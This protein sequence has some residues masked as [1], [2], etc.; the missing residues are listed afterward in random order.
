MSQSPAPA[1]RPGALPLAA[2]AC[3]VL[4]AV[5]LAVL[6]VLV[7]ARHGRPFAVDRS[8]HLWSVHHRPAGALVVAR[9]VTAT[10]SGAFPYVCAV[11]AGL[12]A[13][14]DARGRWWLAASTLGL[15]LL[16]QATR[17]GLIR[18]VGRARP[19]EA[20]WA[21]PASNFAF[22]SGHT[23]TSAL[24]AGMLVWALARRYGPAVAGI[25]GVLVVCWALAV[26]LSRIYLGMHWPSDVLGGWLYA[27]TWLGIG[28]VL[29]R[30]RP[31]SR[32]S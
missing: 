27:A 23:V 32:W 24:V 1:S 16:A 21:A 30:T 14:R 26:G 17:Y 10:G 18:L 5:L 22:P 31:L 28:A 20:D 7:C 2:G 11:A 8:L 9:A 4:F 29:A 3:A 15:L 12:I 25:G 6:T 13:G 19:D